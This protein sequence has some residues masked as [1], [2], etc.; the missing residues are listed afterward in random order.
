[1]AEQDDLDKKVEAIGKLLKMFKMERIVYLIVTIV[2][3]CS[4]LGCAIYLIYSKG[5]EEIPSIIGMFGSSGGIAFTS[6]RLLKM[7]SDALQLLNPVGRKDT[8]HGR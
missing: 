3:F 4:L 1:M 7:W 8:N 2:S 6:G 5:Q